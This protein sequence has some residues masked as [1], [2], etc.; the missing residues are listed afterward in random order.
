VAYAA[1]GGTLVTFQGQTS[2]TLGL[3]AQAQD[4]LIWTCSTQG[5]L[6]ER[7]VANATLSVYCGLIG[8]RFTAGPIVGDDPAIASCYR[9]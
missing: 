8:G 5:T 9:R 7:L 1:Q 2:C 4:Q 3:G 6:I